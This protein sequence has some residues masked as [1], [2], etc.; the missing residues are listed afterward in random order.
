MLCMYKYY[1]Y[2]NLVLTTGRFIFLFHSELVGV[3]SAV[4]LVWL[5]FIPLTKLRL[6]HFLCRP[7]LTTSFHL[8]FGL[9]QEVGPSSGS[10][11]MM[12]LP[13][14]IS[15]QTT[16]I[17]S[18]KVHPQYAVDQVF[19]WAPQQHA[20]V[21]FLHCISIESM[22]GHQLYVTNLLFTWTMFHYHIEAHFG[23]CFVTTP[24]FW[25]TGLGSSSVSL[26]SWG[27]GASL[28]LVGHLSSDG[29]MMKMPYG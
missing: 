28:A 8:N 2:I 16:K 25:N 5:A 13:D 7:L 10:L 3:K 11:F 27:E 9:L 29:V 15:T 14:N 26:T 18:I 12:S 1:V 23:K 22:N 4:S 24:R 17:Y 19:S 20:A 6:T 21:L